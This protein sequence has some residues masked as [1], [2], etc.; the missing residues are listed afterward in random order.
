VFVVVSDSLFIITISCV[1]LSCI[2]YEWPAF[3]SKGKLFTHK[4]GKLLQST[5]GMGS[6]GE[7]TYFAKVLCQLENRPC[8]ISV[9]TVKLADYG[10]TQTLET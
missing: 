9:M 1:W 7:I 3:K 2:A 10:Q 5:M 8:D 4:E 6:G